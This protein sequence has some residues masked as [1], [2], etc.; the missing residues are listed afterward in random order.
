MNKAITDGLILM[1]PAFENGLDVWSSEDGTPGSATYDG[2]ANATLIVADQ[3]FGTCLELIKTDSQQRLRHM[4]ETPLLPGCYLRVTARIKAVSGNL[5][6]VQIAAWAG[7]AGSAHVTGLVEVGP[8]TALTAY[9]DVVEVSAIIGAGNRGGVDMVWGTTPIYAHIGLDLTGA[10]GGVVRIDDLIV[11]DVTSVYHRQ[12][13]DWVDVRDYGAVGDG[14]TDDRVA[15][16]AADAAAG[17]REVLVPAGTYLLGDHMTFEAPVRF[18]GTVSMAADKRL[19]LTKNFDLPTYAEA[20]GDELEGFK[21]AVAVMF[22]FSDHDSLDM[23]GRRIDVDGPIDM[24]GAVANKTTFSQRRVIRNGQFNAVASTNWD[25]A[26]VTSAGTYS[27]GNPMQLTNVTDVAN[28][29]IGSLVQGLG[30]GREVYVRAKNVGAGTVTLSQPL[31]DAVGTQT[32]TF[33]RFR[34]LLDFAGFASLS[35]FVLADVELNCDGEASGV[36]LPDDGLIF[37]MRDCFVTKPRDRGVTSAGLGCQGLLIDRCQFISN[38]QS[39]R[40]QDRTTIALNVN[41]NDTKLRDNRVVRFAHFAVMA[42]T[43]HLI[44]SNHWFQGDDETDGIRQPGLVLTRTNV[45]TTITA[46]YVDNSFIEWSNEHDDEPEHNNE[47]SF[48]GLTVTGNVF[49]A[50]DVAAWFRWFVIKPVGA[51]HYIQGLNISGNTFKSLNGS[52]DRID[53]VDTTYATLDWTRARNITVQGNAFN[54]VTQTISNPVS[55]KFDINS[56]QTVW[57]CSF[58]GYLPF[59]GRLRNVTALVA[60]DPITDGGGTNVYHMP[61]V[62]TETGAAQNEAQVNWPVAVRGSVLLTG[63]VDNPT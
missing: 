39:L 24:Q 62:R 8:T 18:E 42:G 43:G 15:F 63:R 59:D 31:F 22:N 28:I 37:Q 6:A 45:K 54:G 60:E 40:S 16:E 4:G 14:I 10:N 29:E 33:T 57:N 30:V 38:E 52:I 13:M 17:G 51:G 32:Y 35:R 26:I 12:L 5:P 34:Y 7:G 1:P 49:T 27:T 19:A 61:Y 50:N 9:G 47:L 36:M 56:A 11:E 53:H 3:D 44:T 23:K 25:P 48:G 58:D 20:F 46:N 21:R 2:A 55:L 41:A